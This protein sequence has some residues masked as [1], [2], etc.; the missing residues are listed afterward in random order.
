VPGV[1]SFKE[2]IFYFLSFKAMTL[3]RLY[4]C[5]L[6][7]F[8]LSCFQ[9]TAAG[10]IPLPIDSV[11]F[12]RIQHKKVRK[13]ITQQ[14]HFGAKTFDDIQPVCF[15]LSDSATYNTFQKSQV[16]NQEINT[17]WEN[18][19][20]QSPSDEF[21]GRIVSFGLLY[22]KKS[23]NLLYQNETF[24]GIEVGQ[25]LF[26]NLRMLSG[27]KNIAVAMEV[28]RMDNAQKVL[29][30]C[31]VDHG[32]TRGTQQFILTPLPGGK[33][34]I[35]QITRYKCKSHLRDRRLYSFFHE[36]IV[37]EFLR[38]IKKRSESHSNA[39]AGSM[40]M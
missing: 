13:L 20:R 38:S 18:L 2:I 36:R 24:D 35:T 39:L 25:I 26:F 21:N 8:L 14:K 34:E 28:T 19:V 30:Y 15:N 27:I 16:I 23:N 11:N 33:T 40:I 9:S 22:S 4:V 6:P 7:V 37:R 5:F 29:E 10:N 17:V 32:S 12:T 1:G 3:R 31:Y